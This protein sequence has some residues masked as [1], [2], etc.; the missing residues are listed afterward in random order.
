MVCLQALREQ[1]IG[2][3][4]LRRFASRPPKS[5]GFGGKEQVQS[6]ESV[7]GIPASTIKSM[8]FH[9]DR[10]ILDA[11]GN[12]LPTDRA[13]GAFRCDHQMST[14]TSKG[15][16]APAARVGLND[17]CVNSAVIHV[18]LASHVLCNSVSQGRILC[19]QPAACQT[20]PHSSTHL[21][22][23]FCSAHLCTQHDD[24]LTPRTNVRMQAWCRR[25]RCSPLGRT[26][27]AAPGAHVGADARPGTA[28]ESRPA[29]RI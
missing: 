8:L 15:V 19:T 4:R 1:W 10:Q 9:G 17:I 21:A 2:W 14:A 11:A 12:L 24:A 6:D 29:W 7:F 22:R 16:V 13:R 20:R 28:L 18:L 27:C 3:D 25:H 23:P 26:L 5:T